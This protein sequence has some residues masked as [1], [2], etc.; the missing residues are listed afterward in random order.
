MCLISVLLVCSLYTDTHTPTHAKIYPAQILISLSDSLL[1]LHS[2]GLVLHRM[3]IWWQIL[4]LIYSAVLHCA[5][6]FLFNKWSCFKSHQVLREPLHTHT[7]TRTKPP[8]ITANGCV[9][10][11]VCEH[12]SMRVCACVWWV[13]FIVCVVVG[14]CVCTFELLYVYVLVCV[15]VMSKSWG[16]AVSTVTVSLG[17]PSLIVCLVLMI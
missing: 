7:H 16:N 10:V 4:H 17:G 14:S 1:A 3:C 11:C 2:N 13:G 15:F 5:P 9:R 8:T 6:T 12:I